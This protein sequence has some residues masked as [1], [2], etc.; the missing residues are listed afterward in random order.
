[1]RK[2]IYIIISLILSFNLTA[3]IGINTSNP[4][5]GLNIHID[6]KGDTT[7]SF[8]NS[9]DDVV[10]D[11]LGRMGIGTNAPEAK[12]HIQDGKIRIRGGNPQED[13][14]LASTN[15]EGLAEWRYLSM[16]GYRVS[17][18]LVQVET[19]NITTTA[20]PINGSSSFL[21][22]EIGLT[23][24]GGTLTLPARFNTFGYAGY[25]I[26]VTADVEDVREYGKLLINIGG[27]AS[28]SYHTRPEIASQDYF[29]Y[30]DY[31]SA[32][33]WFVKFSGNSPAEISL[34][35][36][37]MD[38][39]SNVNKSIPYLDPLPYTKSSGIKIWAKLQIIEMQGRATS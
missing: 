8:A 12:L 29:T 17:E 15:E 20:V 30:S 25:F 14:F 3:Q 23:A 4:K 22:N 32:R 28:N 9:T 1:M 37:A 38:V 27:T 24:N 7:S 34:S 36:Q 18:W 21:S 13:R 35:F 2:Y 16:G 6:P 39:R 26:I 11:N 19:N 33:I 5:S 31:L 10:I